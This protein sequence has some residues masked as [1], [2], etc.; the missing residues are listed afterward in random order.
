MA[1]R[2]S[3]RDIYSILEKS[4][5]ED[6]TGTRGKW[7]SDDET[8]SWTVRSVGCTGAACYLACLRQ[9]QNCNDSAP[10]YF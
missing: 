5:V 4:R 8:K 6:I 1:V 9:A 3:S 10:L 7:L 2:G